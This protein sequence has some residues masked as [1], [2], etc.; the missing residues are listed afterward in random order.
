MTFEYKQIKT[1]S[2]KMKIPKSLSALE[3]ELRSLFGRVVD[4]VN[5]R[6]KRR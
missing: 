2:K 6:S 3:N 1:K 4:K 5:A